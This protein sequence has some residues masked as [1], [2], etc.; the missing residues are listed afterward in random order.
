MIEAEMGGRMLY[1]EHQRRNKT[2]DKKV[3]CGL[4]KKE[5]FHKKEL[6]TRIVL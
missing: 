3:S 2:K 4:Q 1:A 5:L 6:P